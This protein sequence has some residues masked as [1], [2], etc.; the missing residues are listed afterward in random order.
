MMHSAS[1][2]ALRN[3]RIITNPPV[4]LKKPHCFDRPDG[5]YSLVEKKTIQ[6]IGGEESLKGWKITMP[7]ERI[8]P[9]M[10]KNKEDMKKEIRRME[11]E[12]KVS[13]SA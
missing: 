6:S 9:K 11:E 2:T 1:H 3:V 13:A 4:S 7:R 10:W 5:K 12:R 8:V